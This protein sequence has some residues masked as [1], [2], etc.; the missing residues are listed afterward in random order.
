MSTH[1]HTDG[2]CMQAGTQTG[3]QPGSQAGTQPTRQSGGQPGRQA[4]RHAAGGISVH[5]LEAGYYNC[6]TLMSL[7][8]TPQDNLDAARKKYEANMAE[9]NKQG[10][11]DQDIEDSVAAYNNYLTTKI[12]QNVTLSAKGGGGRFNVEFK[13]GSAFMDNTQVEVSFNT[14]P[15]CSITFKPTNE[16]SLREFLKRRFS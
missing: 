10:K 8:H 9:L 13:V 7:I 15:M 1:E 3:T 11:F 4:G 12:P 2:R 5:E 6:D 14:S 16:E